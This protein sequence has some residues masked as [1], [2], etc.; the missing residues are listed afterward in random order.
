VTYIGG[1]VRIASRPVVAYPGPS[2]ER[3]QAQVRFAASQI[4]VYNQPVDLLV[5]P[6]DPRDVRLVA[7]DGVSGA[8][9]MIFSSVLIGVV[10]YGIVA[11]LIVLVNVL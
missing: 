8:K 3:L 5:D 9:V 10:L 6:R 11:G 4:Y 7:A 2:G 1:G